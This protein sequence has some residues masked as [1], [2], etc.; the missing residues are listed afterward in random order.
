LAAQTLLAVAREGDE[1]AADTGIEFMAFLLMRTT[2]TTDKFA[3]LQT[4]FNDESLDV[5]FGLLEQAALNTKKLSH[6]YSQIFERAL[7]ANPDRATSILIEM[8]QSESYETAQ[9]AMGL[10]AIVAAVRPEPLMDGIGEVMLSKERS[11]NFLFRKFPL[12]ALPEDVVIQWL[13]KHGLEGARLLARHVP[14]PFMGNHGP[15]LHPVTRFI[16]ER[17]GNDDSVFSAWFAGIHSGGAFAGSIAD[18]VGQRASMAEPFLNFPIE[19]VRRWARAEIM[20]ADENVEN[21]R[22]REEELF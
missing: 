6:W 12:A 15:D 2:D 20:Y 14:G 16:L 19:A 9:A 5:I 18:H 7:P 10:F 3:W 11:L 4:L 13:E 22:L 21:F 8:M 1:D 17:F